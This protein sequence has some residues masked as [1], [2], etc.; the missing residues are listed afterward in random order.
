MPARRIRFWPHRCRRGR[1]LQERELTSSTPEEPPHVFTLTAATW[2]F[3]LLLVVAGSGKI[4]RPAGTGAALQVVR[5][6][7][8]A[9]LVRALGAGEVGLGAAVL[10]LGGPVPAVLLALTYTGFAVFAERQRR[11]GGACGCFGTTTT[12]ATALHVW[13]NLAAA[14]VATGT[15]VAPGAS[16]PA[17]VAADPPQGLLIALVL[18]VA[19]GVLRLLLTA[20]PDLHAALALAPPRTDA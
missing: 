2:V 7:S 20:V 8:D 16:L 9:R 10:A 12:P 1:R 4:A 15:A 14:A 13:L 19:T 18:A 11:H 17:V 6:P 5:L 3:A